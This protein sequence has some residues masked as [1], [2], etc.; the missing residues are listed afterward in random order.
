MTIYEQ[1][2]RSVDYLEDRVNRGSSIRGEGDAARTLA[3]REAGMSDRSFVTWFQAVT[4]LTFGE[5]AKRRR[6]ERARILLGDPNASVLDVALDSGYRSHEAFTRAFAEEFGV[7][8]ADY[9]KGRPFRPGLGRIA[10]IKEMYMGIIV[11]ELADMAVVFFDG[12]APDSESKA[13]DALDAWSATRPATGK[14][15]RIFGH[16]IDR[17]GNLSCDPD[18]EGY[19]LLATVERGEDSGGAPT[20]VIR[21]GK[22]L[23]TGIEGNFE[24]DPSGKWIADGWKRMNALIAEKGLRPHRSPRWFE[25]ELEP[26]KPGNLRLDLYLEI[27]E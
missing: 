8:P 3:A 24:T 12:F 22:F 13:H 27:G 9:R 2:Q 5:Y 11:K 18:N 7:T 15:R 25:E 6:L 1:I 19:R 23:V 14:P 21:G 4:G 10:L 17:K 16:N 20:T 26:S